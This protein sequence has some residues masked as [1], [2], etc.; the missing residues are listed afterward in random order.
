MGFF[1]AVFEDLR[2]EFIHEMNLSAKVR[3]KKSSIEKKH[4]AA[5]YIYPN[6]L[7]S[8]FN[9]FFPNHK[10]VMDVTE[11]TFGDAKIYVSALMVLFN[12]EPIGYQVVF[13]SDTAMMAATIRQAMIA[14]Q[15]TDL[16]QVII[17]TDQGN[18]YRSYCYRQLPRELGFIP[19]MFN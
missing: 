16:S 6:L 18:V 3:R 4:I 14:R 15:L 2:G 9:A 7:N 8:D 19:S 12:R 11:I 13:H 10:W 5:G 17:H 1:V